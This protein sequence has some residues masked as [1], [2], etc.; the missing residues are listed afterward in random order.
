MRTR[1]VYDSLE[2]RLEAGRPAYYLLGEMVKDG[3]RLEV[4]MNGLRSSGVFAWTGRQGTRPRLV[5]EV[6][7]GRP[8]G[9][10]FP[11]STEARC[12]RAPPAVARGV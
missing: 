2:L 10:D 3:D 8:D 11:I 9:H 7:R 5:A 1:T 12:R 4:T 6:E